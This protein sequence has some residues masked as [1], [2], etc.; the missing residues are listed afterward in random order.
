MVVFG[1]VKDLDS[2]ESVI[3]GYMDSYS[4]VFCVVFA[5]HQ[6]LRSQYSPILLSVDF[7]HHFEV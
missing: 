7:T 2:Q 3:N 1:L 5:A 6:P 4:W